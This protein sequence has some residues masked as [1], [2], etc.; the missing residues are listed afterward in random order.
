M[1]RNG[2]RVV[3]IKPIEQQKVVKKESLLTKTIK[4]I[5]SLW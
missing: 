1:K 4:F 3:Y 5:K 2:K